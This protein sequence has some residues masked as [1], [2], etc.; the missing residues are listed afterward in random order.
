MKR[1]ILTP[2]TRK[3]K[4][5][6][7]SRTLS[8]QM[9]ISWV[10]FLRM[11]FE[12]RIRQVTALS[13]FDERHLIWGRMCVPLPTDAC[14]R[15]ATARLKACS[16]KYPILR[17]A[18]Q[19]F[20]KTGLRNVLPGNSRGHSLQAPPLEEPFA[21]HPILHSR[22]LLVRRFLAVSLERLSL[23]PQA[24]SMA[25]RHPIAELQD[26]SPQCTLQRAPVGTRAQCSFS[27]RCGAAGENKKVWS[28]THFDR[29]R[30]RGMYNETLVMRLEHR[31][32]TNAVATRKPRRTSIAS[33]IFRNTPNTWCIFL[34]PVTTEP[35]LTALLS[36]Y[37]LP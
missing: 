13:E 6:I 27:P 36:K 14:I 18:R 19:R 11:R 3:T 8:H 26:L 7:I 30:G 16:S 15:L 29:R 5:K 10:T 12:P 31:C 28:K 23:E 35:K 1:G 20:P 37:S 24:V 22:L 9:Y 21:R 34:S 32:C 4:L 25:S 17:A 33:H 2:R